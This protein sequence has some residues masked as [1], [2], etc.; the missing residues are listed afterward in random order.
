[1][2]MLMKKVILLTSVFFLAGSLFVVRAQEVGHPYPVTS[3]DLTEAG[4]ESVRVIEP[5]ENRFLAPVQYFRVRP[6]TET[7]E[8]RDCDDCDDLVAVY[9]DMTKHKPTWADN[10]N[11]LIRKIGKRIQVRRYE[12]S[13]K[14]VIIVTGPDGENVLELSSQL[15]SKFN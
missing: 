9:V 1:M 14:L 4:M 13:K 8:G 11:Q 12:A 10:E 3:E 2:N 15:T 7:L 6:Q 5:E